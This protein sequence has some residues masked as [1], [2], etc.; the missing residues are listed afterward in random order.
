MKVSEKMGKFDGILICSDLDGTLFDEH[1]QIS[2]EN[3]KA[4]EYF[5]GEGGYFTFITGRMHYYVGDVLEIVR[6]NAPV[7]C[8]NGAAVYDYVG[9]KY[10]RSKEI[11]HE[12][13]ELISLVGEKFPEIGI[14][15][16]TYEKVVFCKDN[17]AMQY[18]REITGLPDIRIED[19]EIEGGILKIVFGHKDLSEIERMEPLLDRFPSLSGTLGFVQPEAA[20]YEV[21]GEGVH[22]GIA[23]PILAEYLKIDPKK[24]IAIGDN[25][26][27]IGMLK[28]AAM[29]VAVANASEGAKAAADH[30]TVTNEEHAIAKIISDLESGAILI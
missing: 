28:E 14:N 22:K 13:L 1:H 2:E 7:G 20:I 5:K 8:A 25:D 19:Q 23:L 30:I 10:I 11:G 15:V 29:G 27:D 17:E 3:I 26:N 6:P 21:Q 16:N 18:I 24:I 9:K 4:I 12:G